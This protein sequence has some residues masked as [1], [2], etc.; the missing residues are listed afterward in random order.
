MFFIIKIIAS[1]LIIGLVSEIARKFP[2]VG[3]IIAA[4]PLVSILSLIWLSVQGE[5]TRNMSN[6]AAGVLWG[7]PAT[8]I[9]LVI[10]SISL[11][12]SLSLYISIILGVGGWGL[13]ILFQDL[14]FKRI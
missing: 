4:L 2:S 8:A 5:S 11:K 10:I 9:L 14:L 1:A 12:H 7:F 13:F 3:G 6:F